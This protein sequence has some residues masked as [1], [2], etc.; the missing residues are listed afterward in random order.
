MDWEN[1]LL[2][3]RLIVGMGRKP[4]KKFKGIY[5]PKLNFLKTTKSFFI[6]EI[7]LNIEDL[8]CCSGMPSLCS[9]KD[10]DS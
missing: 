9:L 3:M 1:V 8:F 7:I 2:M 4:G 6:R 10:L 5:F